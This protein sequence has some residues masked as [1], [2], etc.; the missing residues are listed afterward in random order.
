MSSVS[1][2][3][4]DRL[5]REAASDSDFLHRQTEEFRGRTGKEKG[6]TVFK[7]RLDDGVTKQFLA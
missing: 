2:A 5:G 4:G 3:T 6:L 7:V 1:L